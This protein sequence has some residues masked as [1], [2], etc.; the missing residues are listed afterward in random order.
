M[1]RTQ[2]TA[3]EKANGLSHTSQDT[4]WQKTK[5]STQCSTKIQTVTK[6]IMMF[7]FTSNLIKQIQTKYVEEIT[8]IHS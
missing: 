1:T 6:H 2:L 5:I 4:H 3:K 8:L 7:K